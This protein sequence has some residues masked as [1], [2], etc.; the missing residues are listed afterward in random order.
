MTNEQELKPLFKLF[1]VVWKNKW[2]LISFNMV[3]VIVSVIL[4][5]LMPNWYKSTAIV[6]VRSEK[7]MPS[8]NSII[9]QISPFG[10]MFGGG[11]D[12]QKYMSFLQSKRILDQVIKKFKLAKVYD[13]DIKDELYGNLLGN[14]E[15][16]DNEDG[17]FTISC[18]YKEDSKKAAQMANYFY[19]LLDNLAMEVSQNQATEFRQFLE[20]S[21][22]NASQELTN[23]EDQFKVYQDSTL[24]IDYQEQAQQTISN[25]AEM[26]IDRLKQKI[27]LQYLSSIYPSDNPEVENARKRLKAITNNVEDFRN[28]NTYFS[29]STQNIPEKGLDYLRLYRKVQVNQKITEFLRIQLEQAKLDERKNASPLYLLDPAQPMAK[30]SKPHRSMYLI[31]IMFFSVLISIIYFRIKEFLDENKQQIK[32]IL[33]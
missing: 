16:I 17:T 4:L 14:T 1:R 25:L 2:K 11:E 15:F 5:L 3:I 27:E 7:Q 19:K 9:S 18:Y 8:L 10:G 12:V 26:E 24:I 22:N 31:T 6:L 23:A 32:L 28:Q 13:T 29:L 33:Q 20:K 21:Y 30:K